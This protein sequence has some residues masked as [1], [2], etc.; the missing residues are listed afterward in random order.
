MMRTI[1]IAGLLVA[2]A[3]PAA[4]AQPCEGELVQVT[5][6]SGRQVYYVAL[7]TS[8]GEALVSWAVADPEG[9]RPPE[10]TISRVARD[11][12]MASVSTPFDGFDDDGGLGAMA[13][14]GTTIVHPSIAHD[15]GVLLREPDGAARARIHL[16]DYRSIGKSG[17]RAHFDGSQFVVTWVGG[18]D[19]ASVLKA[20]RFDSQGGQLDANPR[21]LGPAFAYSPWTATARIGG[22]TWVMWSTFASG[23]EEFVPGANPDLVGVRIGADG[24]I[25]DAAPV[26]LAPGARGVVAAA[27]GDTGLVLVMAPDGGFQVMT[28]DP[29]GAVTAGDQ[30]TLAA[31]EFLLALLPSPGRDGFTMW[32][33]RDTF[34]G[35][36]V[37]ID[38]QV[39]ARTISR[40]GAVETTP[41]L[42]L[43]GQGRAIATDGRDYVLVTVDET[44]AGDAGEERLTVR[45]LR[46]DT[47]PPST[48]WTTLAAAPLTLTTTEF[49]SGPYEPY[50]GCQA[51]GPAGAGTLALIA[52]GLVALRGRRARR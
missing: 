22:V 18:P 17:V 27:D 37:R 42:T 33:R 32:T 47:F 24:Q 9:W 35:T 28:I 20:V 51:G 36:P 41:S 15:V 45:R 6:Y 30:V 52:L 26:V 11:G 5:E 50:D 16:D 49:C 48:V 44:L 10:F 1:A 29:A 40:T 2:T 4:S 13:S 3:V 7:A 43:A 8:G 21:V 39:H 31:E 25:L 46:G 38:G 14:S 12:A 34:T 19:D 23:D